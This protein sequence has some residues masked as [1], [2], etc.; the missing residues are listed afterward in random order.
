[1]TEGERW[2][3]ELLAELRDG[4]FSPPAWRRFLRE[5]FARAREQRAA[6]PS[7]HRQV[8]LAGVAGLGGWGGVAAAGRPMLGAVGAAWWLAVALMLNW[9][10]GLLETPEGRR[11]DRLGLPNLLSLSRAGLLPALPVLP[12]A[13]LATALLAAA[14]TDVL[15]GRLARAR[16]A[17]TRLGLW[18]D[19]TVDG[20]LLAVAAATLAHVGRLPWWAATLVLLRVALPWVSLPIW[21]ARAEIPTFGGYVSGR[22]PGAV[23]L[24]GLVAAALAVPGAAEL[25]GAGAIGGIATFAA[26]VR[27]DTARRP[28]AFRR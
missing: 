12:P 11:V 28:L 13:W 7:A 27:G 25:A 9:H 14:V 16:G 20:L 1:V 18:L 2:T 8:V 17:V 23:L 21:F 26:T 6:H 10:L 4:R 3:R 22:I 15:D 19:G 24:A 5:S